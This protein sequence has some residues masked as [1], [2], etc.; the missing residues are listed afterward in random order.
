MSYEIMTH[1]NMTGYSY[2]LQEQNEIVL[3]DWTPHQAEFL[4][5]D[6]SL[7]VY[8]L[9]HP[10]MRYLTKLEQETFAHALRKSVKLLH[11]ARRL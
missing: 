11:V 7:E 10:R 6:P 2:I 8:E 3:N 5:F 1:E 9:N 4:S